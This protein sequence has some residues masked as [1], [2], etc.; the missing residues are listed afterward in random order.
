MSDRLA[1]TPKNVVLTVNESKLMDNVVFSS[2]EG[3]YQDPS[4]CKSVPC[5]RSRESEGG[6]T[7]G[8]LMLIQAWLLLFPLGLAFPL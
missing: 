7:G 1:M 8:A 2:N 6:R 5:L 4:L 3:V